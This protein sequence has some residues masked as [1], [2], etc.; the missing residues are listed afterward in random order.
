[1]LLGFLVAVDA[2][3]RSEAAAALP[4]GG[5]ARVASAVEQCLHFYL[6]VGAMPAK[7]ERSLRQLVLTLRQQHPGEPMQSIVDGR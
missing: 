1:M 3:L 4:D 2:G 6:A 7:N 5:L